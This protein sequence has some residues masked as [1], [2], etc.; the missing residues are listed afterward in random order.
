MAVACVQFARDVS[1]HYYSKRQFCPTGGFGINTHV[2]APVLNAPLFLVTPF[3]NNAVLMF[4]ESPSCVIPLAKVS[5]KLEAI[6]DSA[7]LDSPNGSMSA[8]PPYV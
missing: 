6:S 7:P 4:W 5:D 1:K 8:S 3:A 2:F